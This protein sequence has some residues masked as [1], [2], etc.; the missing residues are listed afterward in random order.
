MTDPMELVKKLEAGDVSLKTT[1]AA[2]AC[3]REM[4]EWRDIETAPRQES[5]LLGSAKL[6]GW[7]RIGICNALGEWSY[8]DR[9]WSQQDPLDAEPTHW[10]PLPPGAEA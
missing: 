5:V 2:A 3:I 9:P 6:K 1:R 8:N 7:F 10:L 4:V